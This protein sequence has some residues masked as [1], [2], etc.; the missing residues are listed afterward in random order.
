[1]NKFL[2]IFLIAVTSILFAASFF[3]K[4]ISFAL[5]ALILAIILDKNKPVIKKEQDL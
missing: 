2:W 4:E 1:M 3:I 5:I